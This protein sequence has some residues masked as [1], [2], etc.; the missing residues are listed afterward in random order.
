MLNVMLP[1]FKTINYHT[2]K[3]ILTR[4]L[5]KTKAGI[6]H[7]VET[8]KTPTFSNLLVPL[9]AISIEIDNLWLPIQ[10]LSSVADTPF[11]REV[12]A[13]CLV[14]LSDF[15]S[16]LSQ[17][18]PLYILLKQM[19][20]DLSFSSLSAVQKKLICHH[21]KNFELQ[22]IHLPAAQQA[23]QAVLKKTL[24]ALYCQFSH[25]ILDATTSWSKLLNLS[26]SQYDL[27][28]SLL[29]LMQHQAKEHSKVGYLI[30]LEAPCFFPFMRYCNHQALRKEVYTA[31]YT[32][33][34]DQNIT[35]KQYDNTDLMRQIMSIRHQL[36][37]MLGF[38]HYAAYALE[39]KMAHNTE[40][41]IT[42]LMDLLEKSKPS[43]LKE[44]SE[45]QSFAA[46]TEAHQTLEVWDIAYFSEKMRQTQYQFNQEAFR[47]WFPVQHVLSTLF[48]LISQLFSIEIQQVP[49][50]AEEVW[51]PTVTLYQVS[52]NS[53]TCGYFYIDLYS[54]SNK[55]AGAW[56]GELRNRWVSNQ[57]IQLPVAF[58]ICNFTKPFNEKPACLLHDEV[59]TLFHE[60]GH[61]LHHVLTTIEYP[62]LSGIH[63]VPRDA[64]ELPSQLLENWCWD[65]TILKKIS[66]HIETK[67]SLSDQQIKDLLAIKNF[68]SGL[69]LNRQLVLALFDIHLH[70]EDTTGQSIQ[71]ILDRVRQEVAVILPPIFDRFQNTFSHLF[72]GGYAAGYYGYL[73]SEVLSADIFEVFHEE[74]LLNPLIGER[75]LNAF[76]SQGGSKDPMDMF[77]DFRGRKPTTKAFLKQHGLI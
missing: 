49:I 6:I 26:D 7:L 65:H 42:F 35:S 60:F 19:T 23:E 55:H 29:T 64:I 47:N 14:L 24:N 68:Q 62:S 16:W 72:D 17:Y 73:W 69:M 37:H 61:T 46:T 53:Q 75:F 50:T 32:L 27:P 57:G 76:L 15:T 3:S 43:A 56:M 40:K 48:T 20:T 39:K 12:Y 77:I 66:H 2:V 8:T 11:L 51:H 70:I 33:A 67:E 52:K 10:H 58:L 1:E 44:F 34:S 31:Y 63:G 30:T 71:A 13:D 21:V 38:Q 22:G 74:G 54:R 36:A 59:V 41:V 25:N 28:D 4:L 45:L 5:Q 18:F 9:E